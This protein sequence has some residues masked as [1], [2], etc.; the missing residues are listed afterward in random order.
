MPANI[1]IRCK[2]NDCQFLNGLFCGKADKVEFDPKRGCLDYIPI[3]KETSEDDLIEDDELAE[4]EEEWLDLEDE[5]EEEDSEEG[6]KFE[7]FDE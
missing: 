4:E 5:G 3:Q 1:R 2:Y 7:S 6:T